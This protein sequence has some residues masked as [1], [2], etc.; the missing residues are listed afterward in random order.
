M[1]NQK[2]TYPLP[3][4]YTS[5][6]FSPLRT[7]KSSHHSFPSNEL[8][9]HR[10]SQRFHVSYTSWGVSFLPCPFLKHQR[11]RQR[12]R[13]FVTVPRWP[14]AAPS[15][16]VPAAHPGFVPRCCNDWWSVPPIP[17]RGDSCWWFPRK[18][19]L[20]MFFEAPPENSGDIIYCIDWCRIFWH[21]QFHVKG[22][23]L[24]NFF[25]E[26]WVNII[27]GNIGVA[28]ISSILLII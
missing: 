15:A 17:N 14:F 3:A 4:I 2:D 27:D 6:W 11:T 24:P 21:Q 1:S 26:F 22:T 25:I 28:T 10:L 8:L 23:C 9:P 12:T 13:V 5:N 16:F 19:T 7:L 20:G 18:G